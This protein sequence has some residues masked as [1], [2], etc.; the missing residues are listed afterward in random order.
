MKLLSA[1]VG[2][3][4]VADQSEAK[5]KTPFRRRLQKTFDLLPTWTDANL[6]DH[7]HS[8][9]LRSDKADKQGNAQERRN[10]IFLFFTIFFTSSYVIFE[11]FFIH[12]IHF[13]LIFIIFHTFS[14]IFHQFSHIS[15]ISNIFS[16]TLM[17]FSYIVFNYFIVLT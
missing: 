13:S 5:S 17:V 8:T 6:A 14:S 1:F 15:I 2:L 7:P 11:L 12:F 4:L 16:T 9:E 3:A 10:I